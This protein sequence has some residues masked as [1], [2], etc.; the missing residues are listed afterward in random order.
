MKR[1]FGSKKTPYVPRAPLQRLSPP[2]RLQKQGDQENFALFCQDNKNVLHAQM[3]LEK[4]GGSKFI[5]YTKDADLQ[6]QKRCSWFL[7]VFDVNFKFLFDK[8]RGNTTEYDHLGRIYDTYHRTAKGRA[9]NVVKRLLGRPTNFQQKF[10]RKYRQHLGKLP[11]MEFPNCNLGQASLNAL[12]EKKALMRL[13][14]DIHA[15]PNIAGLKEYV[16]AIVIEVFLAEIDAFLLSFH[17]TP[18]QLAG[19]LKSLRKDYVCYMTQWFILNAMVGV[20]T[21]QQQPCTKYELFKM[22]HNE[23]MNHFKKSLSKDAL[24]Q[25]V[26]NHPDLPARLRDVQAK[27]QTS[28]RSPYTQSVIAGPRLPD[29]PTFQF[30][31]KWKPI[32]VQKRAATGTS[33]A[34]I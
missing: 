26:A 13:M 24:L 6:G 10:R 20:F 16:N 27:V 12:R 29:S 3:D 5:L 21:E 31:V 32:D 22:N 2:H 18:H 33:H 11:C 25:N 34:I 4:K 30:L 19:E 23:I 17:A 9:G 15:D 8:V 28:K 7:K 14:Y 1:I